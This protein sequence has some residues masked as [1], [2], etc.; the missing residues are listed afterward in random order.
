MFA[1]TYVWMYKCGRCIHGINGCCCS[2]TT[3]EC[4]LFGMIFLLLFSY[5]FYFLL[6]F[7][8]T[9]S[10]S[11]FN[12]VSSVVGCSSTLTTKAG[13]PYASTTFK[14]TA[15]T[16]FDSNENGNIYFDSFFLLSSYFGLATLFRINK[17]ICNKPFHLFSAEPSWWGRIFLY[18]DLFLC[19]L[20]QSIH[21]THTHIHTHMTHSPL[22]LWK[23][24]N[25]NVEHH[26]PFCANEN[27]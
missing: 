17:S 12:F 4:L 6:V 11:V 19:T 15:A 26:L 2:I 9:N 16:N 8:K 10:I 27:R 13:N 1:Y 5:L 7:F 21:S 23:M 18:C 20:V 24:M 22:N 3:I 25:M 14:T